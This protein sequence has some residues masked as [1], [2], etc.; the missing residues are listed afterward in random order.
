[1]VMSDTD[2]AQERACWEFRK[3]LAFV[4][5][6]LASGELEGIR[7][8]GIEG[9]GGLSDGEIIQSI[10]FAVAATQSENPENLIFDAAATE[11]AMRRMGVLSVTN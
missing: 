1:M 9:I 2:A 7:N 8:S 11:D 6:K 5:K 4:E 3:L 10:S